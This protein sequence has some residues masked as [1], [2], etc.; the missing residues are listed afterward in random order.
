[1]GRSDRQPGRLRTAVVL[2]A[3][4]L[5]LTATVLATSFVMMSDADLAARSD[6]IAVVE[7]LS[8][9]GPQAG[10]A[11]RT[12]YQV[13]V[14][15]WL[16]NATGQN[17]VTVSVP[18]GRYPDGSGLRIDASPRFRRG[19]RAI[20]FLQDRNDGTLGI[21]QLMLGAFHQVLYR[22]RS[23]A[24][25]DLDGARGFASR[26]GGAQPERA[27][28]FERFADWLALQGQASA[29]PSGVRGGS[30]LQP[31]GPGGARSGAQPIDDQPDRPSAF[32][33]TPPDY[34][35]SIDP[36]RVPRPRF[37]LTMSNGSPIRWFAFDSGGSVTWR[38]HEDGLPEVPG[39]AFSEVEDALDAWSGVTGSTV[40]LFYGGTTTSTGEFNGSDGVNTV[41]FDDPNDTID[42][43]F[44]CGSGGVLA[45]GGPYFTTSTQNFQGENYH[46]A[47]EGEVVTQ[48][49]AGC[50]FAGNNGKNAAEVFAHEVGHA[51]GL[52][53]SSVSGAIMRSSAYGDGRGASLG[54]DDE[55][56][57]LHLYPSEQAP[58]PPPGQEADLRVT[59]N[60]S[61]DP[62]TAG[63]A[64]AYSLEVANNGPDTAENV[65]LAV[66][67][68]NQTD[69]V[70]ASSSTGSCSHSV[71][72]VTCSLGDFTSGQ[73]ES[74]TVNVNVESSASGT[75]RSDASVSSSTDDPATGN[76]SD[77]E[78]TF[79]PASGA[80][81]GVSVNDSPDPAVPGE[82]I[83]YSVVVSNA[84][85]ESATNTQL[86]LDLPIQGQLAG[87]SPGGCSS[88][89]SS[90]NCSLGTVGAGSQRNY[91]V[92]WQTPEDFTGTLRFE[93][94]VE[95]DPSDPNSANNRRVAST[96]VEA[97]ADLLIVKRDLSDPAAIGRELVYT[98]E[99]R[100]LGPSIAQDVTAFDDLPAQVEL[101]EAEG[102]TLS[103]RQLRCPLGDLAPAQTRLV[104]V[105]VRPTQEGT[106]RNTARVTSDTPDPRSF[107]NSDDETTLVRGDSD[108][109]GVP[110]LAE[111]EA[112]NQGDGNGDGTPDRNQRNVST[113][114]SV[115]GDLLTLEAPP[116][117]DLS[118][119]AAQQPPPLDPELEG[120]ELPSGL[121][122]FSASGLAPGQSVALTL[123]M[124]TTTAQ[125]D[126]YFQYGPTPQD[127]SSH[128]YE[129][130]FDGDTG[131]EVFND[132]V[133]LHF[134]DGGRGDADR[135]ANGVILD[136]GGPAV[137]GRTSPPEPPQP[138]QPA[139]LVML[140]PYSL[141]AASDRFANDF[142]G[143]AV[144]SVEAQGGQVLFDGLTDTGQ[145]AVPT[146]HEDLGNARQ[147]SL[148][149]SE[150][151]DAPQITS[152]KAQG[153]GMDIQGFFMVGDSGL[154][155]LDG[156]GASLEESNDLLFP[157]ARESTD[158]DTVLH[159][160]NPG[161]QPASVSI[162]L[163]ADATTSAQPSLS[164]Q[165]QVINEVSRTLPA[166]GTL[167]AALSDLFP[168]QVTINGWMAVHSDRPLK[169]FQ[170][171]ADA[172]SFLSAAGRT[173]E[174]TLR[175]LAPHFFVDANGGG[176]RL[177][178]VNPGTTS[179]RATVRARDDASQLLG[180]G[181]LD[182]EPNQRR[183]A[184]LSDLLG[185]QPEAGET[186]SGFLEVTLAQVGAAN[187]QPVPVLGAIE[188]GGNGFRSMLPLI[189]QGRRDS[190]FLHLAQSDEFNIFTGLALLN[191]EDAPAPIT[192]RAFAPDGTLTASRTFSL[193]AGQRRVDLLNTPAFFGTAFEQVGGYLEVTADTP[194]IA[195]ALFG[196]TRLRY[197]SAIESQ[198]LL[199]E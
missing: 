165:S 3:W 195:F 45:L 87:V 184:D 59:I 96:R 41:L 2:A 182:L 80:D 60:D 34:F 106:L 197:L 1:M 98:L 82:V 52:A 120:V 192:L 111:D 64:L 35:T 133:V 163:L 149:S 130:L 109:D 189:A 12:R 122:G 13:R 83:T 55:A 38:A 22:G 166:E 10:E 67:L 99:V 28:D 156:I 62:A 187:P 129:F 144:R 90:L 153:Q 58:P 74:V 198:P 103:G 191:D 193:Q 177:H 84:G 138:P 125:P 86:S 128:W 161:D 40:D 29:N 180:Q 16:K 104:E 159:L 15:R 47:M 70:S 49:G 61:T 102:C 172:D 85:P 19:S 91:T 63:S 9:R 113:L 78:T 46:R 146:R 190:L 11:P 147:L 164:G 79:V 171:R 44:E 20:L 141:S 162:T 157:L 118:D 124:H 42:G 167:Q 26:A 4:V 25:R 105:V 51:L 81:V 39:G 6:H 5:A 48:D 53:H 65:S 199:E 154:R 188:F 69:Y 66:D 136:P 173:A 32:A 77:S 116:G 134:R 54:S 158:S 148:T 43:T 155:R 169:G 135:S 145:P 17:Q 186:I 119:V 110:D 97:Q 139:P 131:A 168:G 31:T 170:F 115:K 114:R 127:P 75:L 151:F 140:A 175:L 100:N 7:V 57:M 196:D 8:W 21:H 76:N 24:L 72:R 137:D 178:L 107:N 183:S 30:Q 181:Q 101:V 68:S 71:G 108:F 176:S 194:V 150:V 185:L 23:L 123:W 152:I 179:I 132:R 18:G 73:S 143:L 33:D 89:G 142:V 94:N 112:P 160:F 126:S 121:L 27:R 14:L 56:A 37:V 174:S 50:F 88:S 92:N 117:V 36:R 93:A 95:A